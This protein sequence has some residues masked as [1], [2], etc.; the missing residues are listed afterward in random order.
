MR[1]TANVILLIAAINNL[2]EGKKKEIIFD[3][4][5]VWYHTTLSDFKTDSYQYHVIKSEVFFLYEATTSA[6]YPETRFASD[7]VNGDVFNSCSALPLSSLILIYTSTIRAKFH[8]SIPH[9]LTNIP[10]VPNICR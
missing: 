9:I 10:Q 6:N 8:F 2:H 3:W 7:M 5:V 4:D 1:T